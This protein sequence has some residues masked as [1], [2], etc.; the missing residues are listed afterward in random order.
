MELTLSA[1]DSSDLK[2][3]SI[4]TVDPGFRLMSDDIT[5][6]LVVERLHSNSCSSGHV[7]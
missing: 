3:F 6:Y 7:T 4:V 5:V 1:L 2:L